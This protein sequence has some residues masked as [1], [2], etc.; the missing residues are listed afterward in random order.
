MLKKTTHGCQVAKC[1]GEDL[2]STYPFLCAKAYFWQ[3]VNFYPGKDLSSQ[4]KSSHGS[5]PRSL[6]M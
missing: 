5:L 3:Y 6:D 1:V 2:V 4:G